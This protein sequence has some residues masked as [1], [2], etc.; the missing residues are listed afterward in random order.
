MEAG[1][2]TKTEEIEKNIRKCKNCGME[3]YSVKEEFKCTKCGC[4]NKES[5]EDGNEII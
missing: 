5:E 2:Q 4:V 1:K 3:I